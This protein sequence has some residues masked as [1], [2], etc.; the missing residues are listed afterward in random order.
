MGF[1]I[2][3]IFLAMVQSVTNYSIKINPILNTK[4]QNVKNTGDNNSIQLA[5]ITNSTILQSIPSQ[6]YQSHI[7][8]LWS[9]TGVLVSF[10][11]V[12]IILSVTITKQASVI[13]KLNLGVNNLEQIIYLQSQW[14]QWITVKLV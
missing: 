14:L 12:F 11:L 1:K 4:V 5:Q 3:F 10:S 6:V 2:L 7:N 8:K 9:T 13:F